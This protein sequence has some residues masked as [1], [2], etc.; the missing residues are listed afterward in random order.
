MPGNLQAFL[1]Q[2]HSGHGTMTQEMYDHFGGDDIL[3]QLKK[4]DPNVSVTETSISGGE[5]GEGAAGKKIDFDVSKLP[6][7]KGGL[8]LLNMRAAEGLRDKGSGDHHYLR[9]PSAVYEDDAYGKITHASN[10]G[11]TQDFLDKYGPVIGPLLVSVVAPMAA[12]AMFAAMSG[13]ALGAGAGGLAAGFTSGVTSGAA[14]LGAGA[15][16]GALGAGTFTMADAPS[17]MQKLGKPGTLRS[18]GNQA[19]KGKFDLTSLLSTAAGAAGVPG[20]SYLKP[21]L[22]LA[23]VLSQMNQGGGSKQPQMDPRL[24]NLL[25]LLAQQRK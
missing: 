8:D 18:L 22:S 4:Y 14:G 16:P 21:A 13:G 25:T 1:N 24:V 15:T 2:Y 3:A 11:K 6:T 19:S 23:S 10:V 20:A 7:P 17:W 12:P 5:G 9:D